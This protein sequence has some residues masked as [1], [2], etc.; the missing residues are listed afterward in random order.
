MQFSKKTVTPK[1]QVC[2]ATGTEVIELSWAVLDC[3]S[4]GS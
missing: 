4:S 2:C 3:I 1:S